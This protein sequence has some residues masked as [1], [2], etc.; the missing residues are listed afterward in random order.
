MNTRTLIVKTTEELENAL[1][2]ASGGDTIK[3]M[4]GTYAGT[5]L[6]D[7]SFDSPVTIISQDVDN[8]AVFESKL[9]LE[10]IDNL[11][12][13]S[14][15]FQMP[16]IPD[17]GAN[18]AFLAMFYVF[19]SSN[20]SLTNSKITGL[21][22]DRTFGDPMTEKHNA[23]IAGLP[24][25][26]GISLRDVEGV[27]I[28]NNE[29]STV[30]QAIVLQ[31]TKN[32]TIEQNY[33]HDMRSDGIV[34][35]EQTNTV[36]SENL[37]VNLHP[38]IKDPEN[39][40]GSTD[41]HADFIQYWGIGS[42][43][44]IDGFYVRDNI[45][46]QEEGRTQTIFGRLALSGSDPDDIT[47]TNFE[48]S[49]NLIYNGHRHGITLGDVTGAKVFNNTLLP[50]SAVLDDFRI[51]PSINLSYDGVAA[52]S[53]AFDITSDDVQATR[54]IDIYNNVGFDAYGAPIGI[55][56]YKFGADNL[57]EVKSALDIREWGNVWL[58]SKGITSESYAKDLKFGIKTYSEQLTFQ[59]DPNAADLYGGAGSKYHSD[60]DSLK[61]FLSNLGLDAEATVGSLGFVTGA[62][63]PSPAPSVEAQAE[64]VVEAQAEPVVEAQA[65][66]L[67][68]AMISLS[69]LM[70]VPMHMMFGFAGIQ[71]ARLKR[72][73]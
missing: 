72:L 20:I 13:D 26:Y 43:S 1:K 64:P 70:M 24:A 65:E 45:F 37:F 28:A 36:I 15:E 51:L 53:A 27:H 9:A 34:G 57:D 18:S 23:V 2:A 40:S 41:D 5:K 62:D 52:G 39:P 11:H 47:F 35:S 16:E 66:P 49:G 58:P 12:I 25:G 63:V 67:Q 29:I 4:P 7:L 19:E 10:N 3:L 46:V 68:R 44:G 60:P 38:Y 32:V 59:I 14:V 30:Y 42:Q 55:K 69:L 22:S 8:P 61:T 31:G 71:T 48:I 50:N 17:K 33:L 56:A 6:R 73:C 54:D 21:I